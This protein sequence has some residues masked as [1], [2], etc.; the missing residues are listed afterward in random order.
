MNKIKLIMTDLD[1]TALQPDR[2]TI[3]KR[4]LTAFEQASR[5]GIHIV[6]ITGR[7]FV[8]LPSILCTDLPW[9]EICVLNNGGEIRHC[10]DGNLIDAVHMPYEDALTAIELANQYQ[11]PI[12]L[13]DDRKIVMTKM[14][15]KQLCS[16]PVRELQYHIKNDLVNYVHIVENLGGY[17][18]ENK[19]PVGKLTL[20]YVQQGCR[21][22]LFQKMNELPVSCV[23]GSP[24]GM[25]ITARLA[26]KGQGLLRVCRYFNLLPENCIAFGDSGNDIAMLQ[27]AGIGVAMGNAPDEVKAVADIIADTNE[28]DGVAK[29]IE[30]YVLERS[31]DQEET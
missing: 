12:E 8:R 28:K 16:F 11:T 13:N 25:E 9:K 18:K 15:Y 26:T 21:S 2:V 27:A 30:K 22:E 17:I 4:L 20:P 14:D 1:G 31:Y 29:I 3:S 6:P 10:S 19:I 24:N 7:Q 5:L 23:W